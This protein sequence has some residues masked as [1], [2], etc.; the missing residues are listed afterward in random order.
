[1]SIKKA[2]F[3]LKFKEFV[4]YRSNVYMNFMFGCVSIVIYLMLWKAI[5]GNNIKDLGGYSFKQM[6]TY[7]IIVSLLSVLLDS[8]DNTIKLS[9]MI[10]DGS[11]H[12]HLL[13]PINFF[14]LD[15][16]LYGAEK[17]IY[18]LNI[19]IPYGILCY[20]LRDSLFWKI[21]YIPFVMISVFFAFMLK[22]FLGCILGLLT[23]W[24]EELSGLLDLW[25]NIENFLDGKLI[26]LSILPKN[27]FTI[28]S[29]LPFKYMLFVPVNIYMGNMDLNEIL[30][31]LC[32]QLF[33]CLFL[34]GMLLLIKK[35]AFKKYSGYGS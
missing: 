35:K 10:E 24:I 9:T 3:K 12:N 15:F 8:R 20:I 2:V 29:F 26:P 27:I 4:A 22:Y 11:I 5:Y 28:L 32:I 25:K 14:K 16:M 18:F 6:I 13:K 17:I 31:S 23:T 21:E 34:W 19:I 33:W 30:Q 1:M 7:Y